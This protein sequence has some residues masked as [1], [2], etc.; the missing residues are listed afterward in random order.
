VIALAS[1]DKKTEWLQYIAEHPEVKEFVHLRRG[2]V[3]SEEMAHNMQSYY[4][5]ANP[6]IFVLDKNKKILANRIDSEK[7]EE[8]IGHF[9]K[10]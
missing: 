7:I 8:F 2:I 3:R 4:I 6:T 5:V 9:D 1:S 10:D